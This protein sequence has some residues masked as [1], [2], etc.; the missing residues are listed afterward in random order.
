MVSQKY[1]TKNAQETYSLGKWLGER[2]KKPIVI[3]L[4]GGLG[5]GKTTFI[6]GLIASLGVKKIIIS[7]S[8]VIIR[9]YETRVN[10]D[11]GIKKKSI[12]YHIDLYRIKDLNDIKTLGIEEILKEK[13]AVIAIEWA[14]KIKE[15][16]PKRRIDIIFNFLDKN[17]REI[18]I[19]FP[20]NN[21]I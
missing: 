11:P 7:P 9:N 4:F 3:C 5:S 20:K 19:I 21:L 14:E 6:Q 10:L 16:L 13:S 15:I 12:F 18:K 17:T 1:L 2:I 8:F